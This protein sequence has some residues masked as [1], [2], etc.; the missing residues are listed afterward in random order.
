MECLVLVHVTCLDSMTP[1]LSFG[2]EQIK[3][4]PI[5]A[6]Q[7]SMCKKKL[8]ATGSSGRKH[9]FPCGFSSEKFIAMKVAKQ[10]NQTRIVLSSS[11][12]FSHPT[13]ETISTPC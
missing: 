1:V 7:D 6:A 5:T 4:D 12:N 9:H 3:S 10:Q 11:S 2:I 8:S 13:T